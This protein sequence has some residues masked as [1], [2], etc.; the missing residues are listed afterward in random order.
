MIT[1]R[2]NCSKESLQ[3]YRRANRPAIAAPIPTPDPTLFTAAT[4]VLVGVAVGEAAAVATEAAEDI[5]D[6]TDDDALAALASDAVLA[7]ALAA[8]V[9]DAEAGHDATLGTM[10]LY[11]LQS[12]AAN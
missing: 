1:K 11:V 3:D 9:A 6:A 10:M 7:D 8:P 12:C 5:L 2:T 4:P